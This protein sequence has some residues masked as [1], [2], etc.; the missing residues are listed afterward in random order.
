MEQY[1]QHMKYDNFPQSNGAVLE[2]TLLYVSFV[3]FPATCSVCS[4]RWFFQHLKVTCR[5]RLSAFRKTGVFPD[6]QV[7]YTV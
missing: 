5:F 6:I 1:G 2:S 3:M 7:A 4:N